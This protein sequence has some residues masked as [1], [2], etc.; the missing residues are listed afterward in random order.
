M[1]T[2]LQ[3]ALVVS[4]TD[5][6]KDPELSDAQLAELTM[7]KERCA[8]LEGIVGRQAE[9]IRGHRASDDANA[10]TVVGLSDRVKKLTLDLEDNQ[11]KTAYYKEK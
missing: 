8:A 1:R 10:K 4:V 7:L 11:T 3:T 5:S 6:E 2:D 9:C